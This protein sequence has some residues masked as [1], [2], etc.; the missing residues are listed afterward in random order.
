M[1][2]DPLMQ[3]WYIWEVKTI[4]GSGTNITGA[5]ANAPGELQHYVDRF[6]TAYPDEEI[7]LGER[8]PFR[9]AQVDPIDPSR[10]LWTNSSVNEGRTSD[11]DGVVIYYNTK[12]KEEDEKSYQPYRTLAG[13]DDTGAKQPP[14]PT[15]REQSGFDKWFEEWRSQ[16]PF[17][18]FGGVPG[19][20]PVAPPVRVPVVPV[21]P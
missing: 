18:F 20:V 14:V 3:K 10:T 1:A 2:Y 15:H 9:I 11:Y 13:I 17:P 4:G 7:E 12:R 21:V 5:E 6:E 19:V 16:D 8:L